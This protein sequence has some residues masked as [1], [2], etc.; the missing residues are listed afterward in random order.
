MICNYAA[1]NFELR[2]FCLTEVFFEACR[3]FFVLL[4]RQV[5]C[6]DDTFRRGVHLPFASN[7]SV[8]DFCCCRA[9]QL[10]HHDRAGV[11]LV[12]VINASLN[13]FTGK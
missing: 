1:I 9:R 6:G 2:R 4:F 5:S 11:I 3:S 8:H 13:L 10:Y 12:G 7:S